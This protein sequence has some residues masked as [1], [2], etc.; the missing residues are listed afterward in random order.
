MTTIKIELVDETFEKIRPNLAE[1]TI[2]LYNNLLNINPKF[3]ALFAKTDMSEQRRML[4][5]VLV[6]A[7]KN[8]HKPHLIASSLNRLGA[9]HVQ[10]GA[11]FT[12]YNYFGQALLITLEEYLGSEWNPTVEK[13]WRDA[14]QSIVGLM[15]EGATKETKRRFILIWNR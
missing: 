8:I 6:L 2:S 13:A 1:F 14:Y 12:Y 7:I 5:G 10:Y 4:M 3:E 15:L 11:N 9:R